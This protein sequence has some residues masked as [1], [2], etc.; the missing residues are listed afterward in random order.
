[1][2]VDADKILT[3]LRQGGSEGN[4][5]L[6]SIVTRRMLVSA[7]ESVE[8]EGIGNVALTSRCRISLKFLWKNCSELVQSAYKCTMLD[9]I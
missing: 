2:D 1:L 6:P 5:I 4:C 7:A 8:N 9:L 3:R